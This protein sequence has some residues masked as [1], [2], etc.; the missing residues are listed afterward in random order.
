MSIS[1]HRAGVDLLYV[2]KGPSVAL[3]RPNH[4]RPHCERL[5]AG[6]CPRPKVSRDPP[7]CHLAAGEG[8]PGRGRGFDPDGHSSARLA[9]GSLSFSARSS[10]IVGKAADRKKCRSRWSHRR[11][12][13]P[14][15]KL[16]NMRRV[17]SSP[18]L[19]R[20][21]AACAVLLLALPVAQARAQDASDLVK[22]E[23]LGEPAAITPGEPFQVGIR[24]TMKEHWHTYWRNPGDSG[25]PTTVNWKLP[26]G[27]TASELEWAAPSLIKL[28][29][30]T[31]FGYEGETVLLARIT[32]PR[33][34]KPGTD[35]TLNADVAFLVCEKIC[36]PGDASV[37]LPMSVAASGGIGPHA[38]V[39]AAARSELP[40][41]SPWAAT[42]D[43]SPKSL[44]LALANADLA[45]RE[46]AFGN[47][48]SLRQHADRQFRSADAGRGRQRD[49]A[50]NRARTDIA[51]CPAAARWRA[52][53]GRGHRRQVGAACFCRGCD[54][55]TGRGAGD[56]PAA[57]RAAGIARGRHPQP[58]AM[59]IPGAV[60][61]DPAS[62]PACLG[63]GCPHPPARARLHGRHSRKLRGAGGC[64]LCAA[65]RRRRDRLGLPTAIARH[66]GGAGVRAVCVRPEP[67]RRAADRQFAD[68][69]RRQ[70]APPENRTVG[71][72]LCRDAGDRGGDALHRA[73]HGG[74]D[75]LR[76]D[77]AVY[78]RAGGVSRAGTGSGAA[79]PR[80]GLPAGASADVAAAG[81]LDGHAEAV[82]GVPALRRPPHG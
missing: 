8:I 79:V 53:G 68:A 3:R 56:Q 44:T 62:D 57:G 10:A 2:G 25:E 36:I 45:P 42:F 63:I 24:L 61:Q 17:I 48:L 71:F 43:V 26:D 72:V 32:P 78:R 49:A 51:K 20:I 11:S 23:L 16:G 37:S 65:R 70:P 64:A 60:D 74:L 4:A 35:V 73:V 82:S 40:Q 13:M 27:F 81:P 14:G 67:V 33:D 52:G 9:P 38:N 55:G 59:R 34:L 77:P 29:P 47:I 69:G 39:F 15:D 6:S 18:S 30:V 22:V 1:E 19:I 5:L 80:A 46:C 31:S 66:G 7:N 41:P 21:A 76:A 28:G 12:S 54:A 58:D 75:R 50:H